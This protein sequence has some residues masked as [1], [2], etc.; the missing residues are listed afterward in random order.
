MSKLSHI[1]D[2]DYELLPERIAQVPIE[3][4]ESAKM[5]VIK[6][7]KNE[8][9][10]RKIGDLPD[11]LKKGDLLVLNNTKVFKARLDGFANNH[12][13][14]VFLLRAVSA[15][16]WEV[17]LRP[18]RKIRVG[19]QIDVMETSC[20]VMEKQVDGVVLVRFS[21]QTSKII[22]LTEKFGQVPIPPYIEASKEAVGSYQTIFADR[23][24][25]VAAPTAGLHFSDDLLVILQK[26]GVKIAY[27]TLHVGIGTFR[28]VKTE[29]L[30]DHIMHAEWAE[31]SKQTVKMIKDTKKQGKHVVAVGTTVVRSLEGVADL[32]GGELP[33]GGFS[34]FLSTFIRPGFSFKV[35]DGMLTNFHLPKSTLLVLVSTFFGREKILMAYK[36]AIKKEYRFF[37]FGDAMLLLP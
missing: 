14:E 10:H 33:E 19:D 37:S 1:N 20:E 21:E 4:R 13:V 25:S 32:L 16:D 8:V 31:I 11:L 5:M 23:I 34:G 6:S 12:P 15:Y 26:K 2:Y 9:E 28:P 30:E 22:E 36:E 7:T 35:I 17:L 24:G 27:I 29:F 18:G 3:P